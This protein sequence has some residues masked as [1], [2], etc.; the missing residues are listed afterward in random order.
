[1]LIKTGFTVESRSIYASNI[2][3]YNILDIIF[4]ECFHKKTVCLCKDLPVRCLKSPLLLCNSGVRSVN[5]WLIIA[6]L[7]SLGGDLVTGI[8]IC[9]AKVVSLEHTELS[10]TFRER[11]ETIVSYLRYLWLDL[12]FNLVSRTLN[13]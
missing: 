6:V 9:Q 2:H 11:F 8:T 12:L 4:M 3:S 7:S 13:S 5:L 10:P 1:M